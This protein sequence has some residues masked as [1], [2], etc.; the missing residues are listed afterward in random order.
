MNKIVKLNFGF[1]NQVENLKKINF[2]QNKNYLWRISPSGNHLD[3]SSQHHYMLRVNKEDEISLFELESSYLKKHLPNLLNEGTVFIY[4][5]F[6]DVYSRLPTKSTS[7][8]S[9]KLN[10][11]KLLTL[12]N[13]NEDFLECLEYIKISLKQN[14]KN[15]SHWEMKFEPIERCND[16]DTQL[17]LQQASEH[18][19]LF[20]E[21]NE[22]FIQK[23]LDYIDLSC[24]PP[25]AN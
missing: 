18:S 6:S 8:K 2:P 12:A 17:I 11:H 20:D 19:P 4:F 23:I 13:S 21:Q 9:I 14:Y 5:M 10:L 25:C 16:L 7:K 24:L 22:S 15:A 3:D 1:S